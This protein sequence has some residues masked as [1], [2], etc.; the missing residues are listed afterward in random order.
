MHLLKFLHDMHLVYGRKMCSFN[1]FKE[2][3]A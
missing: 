2:Q 1:E 3:V